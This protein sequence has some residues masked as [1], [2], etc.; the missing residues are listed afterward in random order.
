MKAKTLML[1]GVK[2]I[3]LAA[4]EELDSAKKVEKH[5]EAVLAASSGPR[6]F[7]LRQQLMTI[8]NKYQQ[9]IIILP[10]SNHQT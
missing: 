5:L 2:D 3:H 10:L 8:K 9:Q 1:A 7:D 6:I 4:L